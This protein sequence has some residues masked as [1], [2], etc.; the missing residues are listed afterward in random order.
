MIKITRFI[1]KNLLLYCGFVMLMVLLVAALFGE[2]LPFVDAELKQEDYRRID[3]AIF[4]P[5]FE[6]SSEYWFGTDRKGR[7]MLSL[8][9]MGA[10][11]TLLI[12]LL[13][14]IIRYAVAI[15]LSFL[16]HK[17]VLGMDTLIKSLNAFFSY[18]PT[19]VIVVMLAILPPVLLTD[20]RPFWMIVI[21]ALVEA[22]RVAHTMKGDFDVLAGK[23]YMLSGL[24]IGAGPFKMLKSYYLPF[25]YERMIVYIISDLGKVM[26][27]LGQLGFIG[28]FISQ[29]LVQV[30]PAQFEIE[31]ISYSWPM[32]LANAFMDIRGPI[33]IAFWPAFAMTF[34]IFTFNMLAQGLQQVP[35]KKDAFM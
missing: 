25:L 35:K 19:I 15:P 5:P 9:V 27:L 30:D 21:I 8:I 34:T 26:F 11:E 32:L 31:N 24:A 28:I 22:G 14:T 7:D 12:V 20:A 33:W 17:R 4:A 1:R 3:G 18:V 6:P 13:V 29:A 2:Y 10:R 16:A 23:E